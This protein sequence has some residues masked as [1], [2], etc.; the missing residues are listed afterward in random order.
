MIKKSINPIFSKQLIWWYKKH[1]RDLPWRR[2]DDP[3]KIWISEMMLQQTTVNAVI[4]FYERWILRFPTIHSVSR[5]PLQ[6]I[7][8]YWQGLGYYARARNLHRTSKILMREY[9]GKFPTDPIKLQRLP[10]FGPYS[11]G[12]VASIAFNKP[13]PIIDAN[14]RRV[15]MRILHFQENTVFQGNKF[16]HQQLEKIIPRHHASEFNQAL[17]ELGALLCRPREPICSLCPVQH[18]CKSFRLGVQEIFPKGKTVT[19]EKIPVVIAIIQKKHKLFV[20]KRPSTGLLADFWEFPGGKVEPGE[21]LQEALRRELNEE[22]GVTLVRSQKLMTTSHFYTQFC[23]IL[24]V[25]TT[26]VEGTLP[27]DKIHVWKTLQQIELL[28]L[29]SGTVKILEHLKHMTKRTG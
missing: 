15:I 4:P 17:M 1:K 5:A 23:A 28:P 24:H 16:I 13:V 29:P 25:Y 11:A 10:G 22:L 26:L 2:T 12:A 7:L 20:Q 21:S 27:E 6:T 3:Y 19:I 8:K 14:I 18:L 9:R